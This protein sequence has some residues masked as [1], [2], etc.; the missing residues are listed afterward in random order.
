[1]GGGGGAREGGGGGKGGI[2]N[3]CSQRYST[4]MQRCCTGFF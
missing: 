2:R 4:V 3:E 1:M